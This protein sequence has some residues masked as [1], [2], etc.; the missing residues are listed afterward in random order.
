MLSV[1]TKFTLACIPTNKLFGLSTT[2]NYDE[3]KY[4]LGLGSSTA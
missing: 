3:D 2:P 4:E 1:Q